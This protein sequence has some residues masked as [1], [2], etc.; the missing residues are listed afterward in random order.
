MGHDRGDA[1][2][3]LLV[4]PR[5]TGIAMF[6][7]SP[8]HPA[9]APPRP[10]NTPGPSPQAEAILAGRLAGLSGMVQVIV[11]YGPG[12]I[13][14]EQ[15][16]ATPDSGGLWRIPLPPPGIYRIVPLGEGSRPV[17]TDPHFLT[18]EVRGQGRTDLDFNVLGTN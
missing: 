17:R 9:P 11:I 12:S 16:R 1:L 8:R 3:A 18:V 14:H 6:I 13:V 10:E 7:E 5:L 4:G 15:G 2:H